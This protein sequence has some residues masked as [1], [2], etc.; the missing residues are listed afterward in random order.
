MRMEQ[1]LIHLYYGEGKGKT[2]AA[3][4]LSL[5]ALYAGKT[6]VILQFL[7]GTQTGEICLL[8]QLGA[9]VYRGKCGDTFVSG[10]TEEEKTET[11][12]IQTE[13]LLS[14]ATEKAD[15]LILDE[16][17]AAWQLD[18]VE[19]S[20]LQRVVLE[21]PME[22]ELVLTGRKPADWM[23]EAADYCTEMRCEKHPFQKGIAARKGVEF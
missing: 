21:K 12:R 15:V 5:R 22:Q 11:R 17:C 18:M 13:N 20:L 16:V 14:A 8:E 10:M 4:G 7:K 9:K 1:G 6:V 2:T 23:L 19:C 3:M